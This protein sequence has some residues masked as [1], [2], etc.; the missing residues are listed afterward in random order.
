VWVWRNIKT[1]VWISPKNLASI[2]KLQKSKKKFHACVPLIEYAVQSRVAFWGGHQGTPVKH[3][4]MLSPSLQVP[5]NNWR[6][7]GPGCNCCLLSITGLEDLGWPKWYGTPSEVSVPMHVMVCYQAG[8]ATWRTRPNVW[9]CCSVIWPIPKKKMW[10]VGPYP[11]VNYNLTFCSLHSRLQHIYHRQPYA[12][13]DLTLCQRRL[14]PPDRDF[15]SGLCT[16]LFLQTSYPTLWI[17]GGNAG[18]PGCSLYKY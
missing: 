9:V 12:G 17:L 16:V 11:R 3:K 14:Y 10:F 7:A 1:F 18:S 8:Q 5:T 6:S 13:V 15:G 4:R 2:L